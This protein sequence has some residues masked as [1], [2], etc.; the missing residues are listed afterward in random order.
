MDDQMAMAVP[1]FTPLQASL[2][3]TLCGRALD[4]RSPRPILGDEIADQIVRKSRLRLR[5]A[6][7]PQE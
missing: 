6:W 7:H 3:L 4:N 2:W 1:T 5:E